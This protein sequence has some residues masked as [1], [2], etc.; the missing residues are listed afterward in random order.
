MIE[1]ESDW[2]AL[3]DPIKNEYKKNGEGNYVLDLAEG[4]VPKA[5]LDQMRDRNIIILRERDGAISRL[6]GYES[7]G[8]LETITELKGKEQDLLDDKL[9]KKGKIDEVIT[10]KTEAMRKDYEK[11]LAD[12]TQAQDELNHK[13]SSLMIDQEA[14]KEATRLGVR[15]TGIPL[16]V[17]QVRARARM[18]NGHPVLYTDE[19][20]KDYNAKSQEKTVAEYVEELATAMPFLLEPNEGGR[21]PAG[22]AGGNGA[23]HR[24]PNPFAKGEG[25]NLTKA[26]EITRKNPQL[27]QRLRE[28]AGVA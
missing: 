21:S 12:A 13:L 5:Q 26:M 10:Q 24:G 22:G 6:K 25:Y 4:V 11:K 19:G 7:I 28:E 8:D 20:K 18:E 3:P 16:V 9:V 1:T 23:P 15:G 2:A 17:Q 27:A 14:T